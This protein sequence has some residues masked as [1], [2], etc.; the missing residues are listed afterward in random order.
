VLFSRGGSN[1]ILGRINIVGAARLKIYEGQIINP[2]GVD[3]QVDAAPNAASLLYTPTLG[4]N[5]NVAGAFATSLK[6]H[7]IGAT[8]AVLQ[9]DG[10]QW[11]ATGAAIGSTGATGATGV[12]GATGVTGST[13]ATGPDSYVFSWFMGGN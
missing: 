4:D 12:A 3:I 1:V 8:G 5:F 13:G 6:E 11:A 9:Y 2:V 7:P 10:A